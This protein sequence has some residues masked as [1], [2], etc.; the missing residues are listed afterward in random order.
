MF[1]AIGNIG[2]SKKSDNTRL[3][4]KDDKY[5]CCVEIMDVELP[6]SD[7]PTN[8]MYNAMSYEEDETTGEKTYIWAKNE[9]L[10]ILYEKNG[11]EYVLTQDTEV[12]LTKTY[13]VDILEHDDF[14]EDFTYGWRYIWE[15][16]TDEQNEEVFN[17]CKQ[18]WIE[19][20]RFVT[21][22]T[23]EEFK[24]RLGEYFVT[25]S[26]LYYYLFTTRYCL[27]DN[28]AKNSFWHYSKTGEVD[29]E[30]NPIRK[31]DLCWGYDFDTALG[32][33]NYGQQ[34][35]RYGLEDTDVDEKGEEVFREMDSTFFCRIRDLFKTELKSMYNILDNAWS[36][37]SLIHDADEWQAEFPEELWRIDIDRKY[38][39]TYNSSFING[40]GNAQFLTVMSNGRMKYHRRQWERSQEKYMASKYQSSIASSDNAV[41]RCGAPSGKLTVQ[42]NYRL[43]LTPYAYMYLNVKYGTQSPIQ[44]RAEPNI[45]Y[46]IPFSGDK[47]DIIDVYSSSLIQD[48]GDLS[49]CYIATADTSKAS[50]V[51]RLIF[52]NETAGYDNPYFTTLT[53]GANYLLE[54][55][56]IEN[57][58]G[59]TQ[60][61]NLTA[62]NNLRE[63]YAH[64]S[65]IGGVTFADGGRIEIAELP[66]IN[67]INMK[68]LMYLTNLDVTSFD[69]LTTI[70]VEN[71]NTVDMVAI[72]NSATKINRVRIVGVDWSVQDTSLLERLYNMKGIDKNGYNTDQSVLTGKV[73]VSIIREQQLYEYRRVWPDLEITFNTMIEQFPVTFIND[74][75]TIL[76]VQYVDKGEDATD[77]VATGRIP[78]PTKESSISTDFT[79]AGWDTSLDAIFSER[80]IKA[81]YTGT[82]RT[83]TVKYVSKGITLQESSGLYGEYIEYTGTTPTYTLEET[84]YKYCL[85]KDWDKSGYIDGNK[86]INAIFDEFTYVQSGQDDSKTDSYTGKELKDLSNVEIYALSKLGVENTQMV[87]EDGDPYSIRVGYDVDYSDIESKLIVEDKMSFDGTNY[88]DTG[89]DL[90]KKDRDFVLALD[91]E[92][93]DGNTT[94]SVLA[95]CF[96]SN[97]SSGFKLWFNNGSTLKLQW[98]DEL[99][100]TSPSSQGYREMLILRHKS[101]DDTIYVYKSNL[102]SDAILT[103]TITTTKDTVLDSTLVLGCA[104]EDDG[105]YNSHSIVDIHWCKVWYKDLGDSICR[106]LA[107]WT[108]EKIG[109][110]MCGQKRFYLTEDPNKRAM[111]SLLA[112]HILE[113]SRKWNLTSTNTGGWAA[114]HLNRF[115]NSRLY[116]AIPVQTK[117]LL[118]KVTVQSSNG[119]GSNDISKSECYITIPA[120]I[121]LTSSSTFTAVPYI[122]EMA[123][124]SGKTI[125]YMTSDAMRRRAYA[126]GTYS[127]YWTR[128]P[129]MYS[130]Y[131]TRVCYVDSS[132]YVNYYS[133]GYA[134]NN[135]GVLIEISF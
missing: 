47:T 89:V 6:L 30:G 72:L 134:S 61:L 125:S 7:F 25:D 37:E 102:S 129:N 64:G 106:K 99:S 48:F 44:L 130:S 110:E 112:T 107:G 22:S 11:D 95:Q 101:G 127:Y 97:G 20:Y 116:N 36:A 13:Y 35:Y 32:L 103:E 133:S 66:A 8:T 26:A 2:D 126:D 124:S 120:A 14:S 27:V 63:L 34:V 100:P 135:H 9:N 19:F 28:R 123:I 40:E 56:N 29:G 18:K 10:G 121:E 105:E 91:Y 104:K 60:A 33:N 75:G 82:T 78:T 93:L 113:R 41:F 70:T 57:I 109:F 90:F 68:N 54:T 87:L 51:K 23:D 94:N 15:D 119:N 38:I 118:K 3:T 86:T 92:Y 46:E 85:F 131:T 98:G 128:S 12:D 108:H 71:C 49:T 69:N 24:S 16:G 84:G 45:S 88:L 132:G 96:R 4:D 73:H 43:K 80:T 42:P 79:Y 59:L 114:S 111:L 52:G 17:Y 55:L 5:E 50:K 67:A 39:R 83:Y 115:L 62:L 65:N 74:D 122:N 21:T 117:S 31:W 58:S 53:T 81:I 76:E 77:P 1:Y